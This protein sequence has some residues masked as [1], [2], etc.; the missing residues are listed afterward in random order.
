MLV[1]GAL[2]IKR[3]YNRTFKMLKRLDTL[4]D[5]AKNDE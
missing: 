3:H 1:V 4:V 2:F 5:V